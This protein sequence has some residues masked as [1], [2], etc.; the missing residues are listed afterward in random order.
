MAERDRKRADRL[1]RSSN[2]N[3]KI[4]S[5]FTPYFKV[6]DIRTL[7]QH[8]AKLEASNKSTDANV[9]QQANSHKFRDDSDRRLAGAPPFMVDSCD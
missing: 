6:D 9:M 3:S 2:F 1:A 8:I 4:D 5:A 7:K